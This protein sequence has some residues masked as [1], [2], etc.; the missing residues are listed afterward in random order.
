M[1]AALVDLAG[2]FIRFRAI[3]IIG[4]ARAWVNRF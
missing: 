2:A 4:A 1:D 3:K